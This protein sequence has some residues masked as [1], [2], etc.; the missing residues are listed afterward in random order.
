MLTWR[1]HLRHFH[2]Q[3]RRGA[4]AR[5]PAHANLP[6]GQGAAQLWG[7]GQKR[8]AGRGE[9][10][11]H[12]ARGLWP[13]A[14]R[15]SFKVHTSKGQLGRSKRFVHCNSAQGQLCDARPYN[16]RVFDHT[17]RYLAQPLRHRVGDVGQ[18]QQGHPVGYDMLVGH[19][20]TQDVAQ[21]HTQRAR[22]F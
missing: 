13:V 16:L 18:C 6:V 22:K 21:L 1:V 5:S 19:N 10:A 14:P 20:R 2:L 7:T 4:D 9:H 17:A 3:H 8:R 15:V 12:A 11:A